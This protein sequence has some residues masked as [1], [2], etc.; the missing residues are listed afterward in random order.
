MFRSIRLFQVRPRVPRLL[1]AFMAFAFFLPC[2]RALA[3]GGPENVLL[4]INARSPESLC[5]AN[6]YAAL[7]HIPPG[8]LLF[9]DWDPKQEGPPGITDVNSFREKILFPVVREARRPLRSREI[10][11]VI[12]SSGFPWGIHIGDD[13]SKFNE[14]QKALEAK[15]SGKDQGAKADAMPSSWPK[16]MLPIGSLNGLTFLYEPVLSPPPQNKVLYVQPYSNRYARTARR[17]RRTSRR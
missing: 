9:L 11:Y 5:I 13:V 4:V 14:Y 12:Y 15:S 2:L 6:H 3:T 10:D 17:S 7:R 16:T 8:N 1:A